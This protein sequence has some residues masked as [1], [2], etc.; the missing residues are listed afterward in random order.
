MLRPPEYYY[1]F[2]VNVCVTQQ[3]YILD[4]VCLW[5]WVAFQRYFQWCVS[6]LWQSTCLPSWEVKKDQKEH[7]RQL[8]A[9]VAHLREILHSVLY[10][11]T[12]LVLNIFVLVAFFFH[13]K[14]KYHGLG[15]AFFIA[16][17]VFYFVW[18]FNTPDGTTVVGPSPLHIGGSGPL[19]QSDQPV[20]VA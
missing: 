14:R 16:W 20:A 18:V 8:F 4:L 7:C 6:C 19:P 3:V 17:V 2:Q 13:F 11:F 15:W 5:H 12:I 10:S 9:R 1:N